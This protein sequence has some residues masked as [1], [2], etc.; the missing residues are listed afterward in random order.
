MV[1]LEENKFKERTNWNKATG[2]RRAFLSW[3]MAVR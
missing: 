1:E 3:M 2:T